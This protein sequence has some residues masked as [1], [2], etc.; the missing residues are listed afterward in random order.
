VIYVDSSVLL[1]QLLAEDRF[2]H[3]SLWGQP[4]LVTSR[5]SEYEVWN[6]INARSLATSHGE[7][8]RHLF[9][10]LA[11]LE[12]EPPV[13]ARAL[14]PFPVAVRTLDALHLA[15]IAFLRT[16]GQKPE[17]ATYDVR[18][19]QAAEALGVPLASL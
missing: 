13:L 12:L 19:A 8:V 7:H 5:L 18:L 16:L 11:F 10:R 15:S 3:P 9:A 4:S 1:A 2:P 6:R 17:L 14:E